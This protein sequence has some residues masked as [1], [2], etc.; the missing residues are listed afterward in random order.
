[1]QE[2]WKQWLTEAL[3]KT[4][5]RYPS[6]GRFSP[7]INRFYINHATSIFPLHKQ[8]ITVEKSQLARLNIEKLH[9]PFKPMNMLFYTY[10][11][12]DFI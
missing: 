4:T 1:M 12:V 6:Q 3:L 5:I 2:M 11:V 7:Q 9:P 8:D 10:T